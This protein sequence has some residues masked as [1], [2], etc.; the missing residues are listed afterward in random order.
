MRHKAA[1]RV[2]GGAITPPVAISKSIGVLSTIEAAIPTTPPGVTNIEDDVVSPSQ[3]QRK[4]AIISP[5]IMNSED[6]V[7]P[8]PEEKHDGAV[9]S[10]LLG[11]TTDVVVPVYQALFE[12][13][14]TSPVARNDDDVVPPASEEPKV[15]NM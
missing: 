8:P 7:A 9:M 14:I 2:D 15:C 11:T 1:I 6:I 5:G 10:P 3:S 13:V 12:P 4:G